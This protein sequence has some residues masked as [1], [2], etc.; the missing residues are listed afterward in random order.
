M[1]KLAVAYFDSTRNFLTKQRHSSTQLVGSNTVA[2]QR[3]LAQ[4]STRAL[5]REEDDDAFR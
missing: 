4:S 1:P 2:N 5:D 3:T